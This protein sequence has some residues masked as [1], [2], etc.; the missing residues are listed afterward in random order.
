[1]FKAADLACSRLLTESLSVKGSTRG[2]VALLLIY[3]FNEVRRQVME[4]LQ[5]AKT[6]NEATSNNSKSASDF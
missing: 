2:F 4:H 1:M 3:E 5:V 6:Y